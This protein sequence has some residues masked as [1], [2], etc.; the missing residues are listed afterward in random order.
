MHFLGFLVIFVYQRLS[1]AFPA[2]VDTVIVQIQ[3]WAVVGAPRVVDQVLFNGVSISSTSLEVSSIIQTLSAD[4]LLPALISVNQTSSLRNHT[5]L[6]SRECILEDSQLHWSVRVF[7]DGKV[8]LTLDH[9]DEWTVHQPEALTLKELWEKEAQWTRAQREH[10][11]EGCMK[12]MRELKLSEA[13]SQSG[14]GPG[15]PYPLIPIVCI[16]MFAGLVLIS[17]LLTK[18]KGLRHPG[19]VVGSIIHY[20]KDLTEADPETK[21]YDYRAL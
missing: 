8:F 12:L 17:F 3:Q 19:G 1:G 10:L 16:I 18:N 6:W 5:V 21:G 14:V 7:Y 11:Q 13:Q 2:P 4:A 9:G 15:I 20:P